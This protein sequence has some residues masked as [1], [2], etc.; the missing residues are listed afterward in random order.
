MPAVHLQDAG[1]RQDLLC[2][3]GVD[4]RTLHVD[5][6]VKDIVLGIL[7]RPVHALFGEE[8]GH[9]RS[10]QTADIRVKVDR[11][12][13]LLFDRIERLACRPKLL[14]GNR[15]AA[16]ALRRSFD[17]PVDMRL[18]RGTDDHNMIGAMPGGHAHAPQ[19]VLETAGRDLGGD[20]KVALRVDICKRARSGERNRAFEVL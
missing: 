5:I 2:L 20:H 16:D 10:G 19:V 17:K 7:V 8:H 9:L 6:A 3:G 1:V 12:S 15:N 11:P 18:A 13:H 4:E 14:S